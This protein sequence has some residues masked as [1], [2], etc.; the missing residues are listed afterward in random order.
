MFS[1]AD[2]DRLA[3]DAWGL[4]QAESLAAARTQLERLV[5]VEVLA[6]EPIRL[7]SISQTPLHLRD[8]NEQVPYNESYWSADGSRCLGVRQPS[9]NIYRMVFFLHEFNPNKPLYLGG[10]E[11]VCPRL[12][13]RVPARLAT[14]IAAYEPP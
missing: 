12:L 1:D 7:G 5:L 11:L 10:D 8:G 6:R 9:G 2:V 14:V 3:R 13:Q 4:S